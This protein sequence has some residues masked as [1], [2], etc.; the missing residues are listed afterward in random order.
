MENTIEK[1]NEINE[2]IEK[3]TNEQFEL[4]EKLIEQLKE[5][6]SKNYRTDK[7]LYSLRTITNNKLNENKLKEENEEIYNNYLRTKVTFDKITFKKKEKELTEK[8]TEIGETTYSLAIKIN[9][10]GEK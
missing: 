6:E 4:K 1:L 9:K 3:L 7:A 2:L 5:T 10:E 8:Y